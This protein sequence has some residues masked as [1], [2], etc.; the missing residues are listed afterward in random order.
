VIEAADLPGSW[1]LV[2]ARAWRDGVLVDS[3]ALGQR[4]EGMIHYLA[5]YRVAVLIAHDDRRPISTGDR[6]NGPQTEM[7]AA[8]ASFDAYAGDWA[9]TGEKELTHKLDLCS[10]E[11]DRR[12]DYVRQVSRASANLVLATPLVAM[13]DGVRQMTL[14]WCK[15][16]R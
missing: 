14:E 6:R 3:H 2:A 1:R 16:E 13:A 15:L 7:A 8:A 11:N 10:F 5:D 4:P 9:I 12:A